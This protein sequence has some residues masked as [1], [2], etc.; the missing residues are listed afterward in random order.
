MTQEL[1]ISIDSSTT[2]CKAIAWDPQGRAVAEG[3]ARY[4]LRQPQPSWHE[5][6][7]GDWWAGACQALRACT[8]QI[9][10]RRVQALGI[11]HQRETFVP[12][13]AAGE[14]LRNAI[15]WSDERS[16]AQVQAL[17]ARFGRD[18]LHRL[19]G[20]PLCMTVSLPK[21]QWLIDH[22]PETI[23]TAAKIVDVHAF[24][25]HRLTG[26]YRTSLASAD[27]LGLVD[28]VQ[29]R[30]ADEL[31]VALG[32]RPEQ[33]SEIYEPG[34]VVGQV[35]AEAA[36]ATGLPAGLPVVA[37]AGDGQCAGLGANALGGGGRI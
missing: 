36:R 24:L 16:A 7:A 31:I 14:P 4:S 27:P 17:E 10:A 11:T 3:R 34:S 18:A 13:D 6:D 22:E 37:G 29:R 30:W 21:I 26:A 19:T 20:K 33:F 2:A 25:V 28:M 32:L 1:V 23:L 15:L 12:L 9:D 8:E 35:T 5:Q